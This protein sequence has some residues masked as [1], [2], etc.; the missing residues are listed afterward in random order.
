MNCNLMLQIYVAIESFFQSL[1]SMYW[2]KGLRSFVLDVIKPADE[3]AKYLFDLVCQ[4]LVKHELDVDNVILNYGVY[5]SV[6]TY[7]KQI[8]PSLQKVDVSHMCY[9]M[10]S[11]RL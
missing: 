7:L 1:S 9:T 4:V 6:Y 2:Y 11:K 3:T 8:C 5:N 10:D